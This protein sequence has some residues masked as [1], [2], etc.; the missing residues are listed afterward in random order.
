MAKNGAQIL[1]D[2]LLEHEV[3]YVFG[4]PG[5]AVIKLFDVLNE[6]P[7]KVILTRHEQ[8][9]GHMADGYARATGKIGVCVATSGPGATNLVTA[10]GT[11]YMDSVPMVAITGQVKTNL[12]GNDAFQEADVTGITRPVTKHN[13]LVKDVRDLGRVI[14]EAFYIATTGRPGPS[15]STCPSTSPP[16]RSRERWTIRCGC[17]ATSPSPAATRCRYRRPPRPSTTRSGP[18]STSAAAC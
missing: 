15:S 12:I 16:R 10:I 14:R 6:S 7:L 2:T 4:L 1:V 8:G 11:A 18:S 13:Y 5:G 9:A 3:E 17:P